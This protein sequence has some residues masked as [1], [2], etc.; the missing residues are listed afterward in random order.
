MWRSSSGGC[1][2]AV[3]H[4]ARGLK[5]M[6]VATMVGGEDHLVEIHPRE[7]RF[8]CTCSLTTAPPLS[9]STLQSPPNGSSS[10]W[11]SSSSRERVAD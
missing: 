9:L 2:V 4:R 3:S 11:H 6:E 5:E 1:V 10:R 8:L 7:L